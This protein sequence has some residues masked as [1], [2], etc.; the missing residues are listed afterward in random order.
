[1]QAAAVRWGF[2]R[3]DVG[4]RHRPSQGQP[5]RRGCWSSSPR[6]CS[7]ACCTR[8]EF[9]LRR[10]LGRR[11][12]RVP[13]ASPTR[14]RG[15]VW[16]LSLGTAAAAHPACCCSR[17]RSATRASF[18]T[19]SNAVAWPQARTRRGPRAQGAARRIAGCRDMLLDE[20][21]VEMAKGDDDV[22]K[23]PALVFCF[24]RDECWSV[25]EQL[26]GLD[27]LPGAVED[28]AARRGQRP[29][30]DAGRRAEA[31]ADAAPRR[32][33]APRRAAAEVPPRRRRAVQEEAAGRVRLHRDAGGRASTCRRDRSCS[34]RS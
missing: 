3:D 21:L 16:E 5:A 19:G 31:Q 33:R 26:K 17:R 4:P 23:T 27:L 28:A 22:R 6:F 32:R 15:I 25:A 11:D 13:L 12:G 1:M 29:R 20:Q 7:I 30:L 14:E 24:N 2:S 9:R 34:P 18:S 10:R 8:E